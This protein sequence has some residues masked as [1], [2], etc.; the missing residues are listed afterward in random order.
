M[1]RVSQVISIP[2]VNLYRLVSF[3]LAM[4]GKGRT[5]C[6]PIKLKVKRAIRIGSVEP[7]ID[8]VP[9]HDAA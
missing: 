7:L 8:G 5:D 1:G 9:A 2:Q 6:K 4:C 3:P